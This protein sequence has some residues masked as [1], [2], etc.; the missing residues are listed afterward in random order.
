MQ[1]F[2]LPEFYVPH[3]AR[4][5]PHLEGARVHSKAWAREMGILGSGDEDGEA[6][7]WDER[8]FDAHDYA[9][10]C[11]Y[12]HPE[13]S[14]DEL[15][16]VTDWYVW[17]FFFD[18]HFLEVYKRTQDT[19][20]ARAYLARLPSF[21]PIELGEKTPEPV[22]IVEK[23]LVD[24]WARTAPAMSV[25]WRRRFVDSTNDLLLESLWEL[26]N[27]REDRVANP[28]EYIEMRRKVGGAPWSAGLVE[29]AVM[30]E[31][32]AELAGTRPLRVLRD[33]FSDAVHLRN[34][35]FSYQRE[36]EVEGENANCVLVV[37]R[38][39]DV[40]AQRAANLTN[41]LLTSRLHQFENTV[42]VELP[43]LFEAHATL[44]HERAAVMKYVQGLQDWQSG[45]HEWHMRSSR[46]MNKGARASGAL[47][48]NFLSAFA[49]LVPESLREPAERL[50]GGPTGLGTAAAR[51][52]LSTLALGLGRFKSHTH[53]P[54]T[55]VGPTR[56]PDF[57]MPYKARVN[58]HLE[59]SRRYCID[60]GRAMGMLDELPGLPGS[61]VWDEEALASYDFA[62]CA[63]RIHPDADGPALDISSA[64]LTWG[65][66]G[67]DY[68]PVL[69]GAARNLGAAKL[70]NDRLELFMPLDCGDTPPPANPLEAGLADLWKRTASPMTA[71]RR[72]W[73]RDGVEEMTDSWLWELMNQI[74][75]RIPDPVDYIE[76]RR[77]TFGSDM[78]MN[79]ARVTRGARLPRAIFRARPLR[80]LEDAAQ[81]YACF[82]NDVFSYQKEIEFEGEFHNCARVMENFLALMPG[83]GIPVVNDLMTSRMKQFEHVLAHDVPG[84]IEDHKLDPEERAALDGYIDGL[85]DWMAGILD[86]HRLTGRYDE[87]NLRR[88]RASRIL[89]PPKGLGTA[90][91]RIAS[92]LKHRSAL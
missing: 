34:D 11:A 23:A 40:D 28:I 46:Y 76:M 51:L 19:E 39:F 48:E 22:E 87:A 53:V 6:V 25:D 32:P 14:A 67:D 12:T 8:T 78:T 60:W 84:M 17:V 70:Q 15:D 7:I 42:F 63:A 13:A 49:R 69:F 43:M 1:P 37:R 44:P 74:E 2:I 89:G 61:G 16:L 75:H 81:D 47:P 68:F 54:F 62:E 72:A 45:G 26:A 56:L 9:L 71:E 64:W 50:L 35:L 91:A 24:L 92:A 33:T 36:V 31:V 73:F 79:L 82:T 18:D 66:Y 20:G 27:I 57:Y 55:P 38:F 41:D 30:A 10:L 4:L 52:P 59:R 21:M 5:N 3:P 80:S 90:G 83:E 65:T 85:K 29:H 77:R 58:P 86:W 88:Q